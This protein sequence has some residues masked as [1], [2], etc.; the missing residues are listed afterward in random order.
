MTAD[1]VDDL[2]GHVSRLCRLI[3]PHRTPYA[4]AGQRAAWRSE[5]RATGERAN[6]LG[7]MPLMLLLCE[8]AQ[9][10]DRWEIGVICHREW[11]GIGEWTA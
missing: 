4:D 8:L 5:L 3:D 2:V 11:T 7:G 10:G 1:D 9:H 6:R